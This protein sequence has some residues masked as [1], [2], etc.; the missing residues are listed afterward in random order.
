MLK[1]TLVSMSLQTPMSAIIYCFFVTVLLIVITTG[2]Q[3]SN[4]PIQIVSDAESITLQWDVSP[5]NEENKYTGVF[6]YRLFYRIHGDL[7]WTMI[8]QVSSTSNQEFTIHHNEFGNGIYE[9]AVSAVGIDYSSSPLHV[10]TDN[11]AEPST[12]W[13]LHWTR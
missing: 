10:S 3:N 12:G 5:F 4:V 13:Y 2:C 11:T 9:F 1:A 7:K 8:G 6:S